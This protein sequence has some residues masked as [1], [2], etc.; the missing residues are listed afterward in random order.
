MNEDE[1]LDF[2][3]GQDFEGHFVEY[4]PKPDE[5]RIDIPANSA[6]SYQERM[7]LGYD[8]MG[9]IELEGRAFR[10]IFKKR[11][12]SPWVRIVFFLIYGLPLLVLLIQLLIEG[13][14]LVL[15]LVFAGVIA[16]IVY[17]QVRAKK[18]RRGK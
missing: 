8:P 2:G 5:I 11:G 4:A 10:R 6:P 16:W 15:L 3:Q 18:H 7:P 1:D 17:S 9:S 13:S 12:V 14:V